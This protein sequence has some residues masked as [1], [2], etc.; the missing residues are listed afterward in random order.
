MSLLLS[1]LTFVAQQ[2]SSTWI[3]HG[4]LRIALTRRKMSSEGPFPGKLPFSFETQLFNFFVWGLVWFCF[5]CESFSDS[6]YI[7][8]TLAVWQHS[9]CSLPR[10]LFSVLLGHLCSDT[11]FHLSFLLF[12]TVWEFNNKTKYLPRTQMLQLKPWSC[13]FSADLKRGKK[14]R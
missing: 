10:A 3:S 8:N 13:I 6:L 14:K 9:Y 1:I 7:W 4:F 5:G 2:H 11:C 12:L